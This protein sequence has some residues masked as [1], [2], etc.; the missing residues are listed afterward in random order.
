M[1]PYVSKG[2]TVEDPADFTLADFQDAV[3]HLASDDSELMC[4]DPFDCWSCTR[5][6]GHT[7]PHAA[8]TSP[9][10]ITAIWEHHTC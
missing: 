5:L 7:G 10:A 1:G 4:F 3:G 2:Y 8:A 9:D 6:K